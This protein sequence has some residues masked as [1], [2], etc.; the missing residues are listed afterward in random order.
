MIPSHL[1][2]LIAKLTESG[3]DME[4]GVDNIIVNKVGKYKAID[5]KTLVYPGFPTDLQQIITTFL[6]QFKTFL[7]KKCCKT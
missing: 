5:I 7:P 2:A 6:T 3:V 4:I 1:E